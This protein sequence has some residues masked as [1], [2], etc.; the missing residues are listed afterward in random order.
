MLAVLSITAPIF[1]LMAVGFVSVK[2]GWLQKTDT[3]TLGMVVLNFALPG[4]VFHALSQQPFEKIL[5]GDYLI[6]YGG[7][8]LVAYVASMIIA[9]RI[10]RKTIQISALHGLGA[11]SSNSGFIGYAVAFTVVGDSAAIGLAL[12]MIIENCFILPVT[13]ALAESQRGRG[14]VMGVIGKSLLS[15]LKKPMVL[16]MIAG[17]AISASGLPVPA[18]VAKSVGMLATAAAPVA[19]LVIGAMLADVRIRGMLRDVVQIVSSK[20]ILHPVAVWGCALLVPGLDPSL[21][22]AAILF[23]SVPM[24]TIFPLLG[25]PYQQEDMCAASLM[26]ATFTSFFTISM[27][28]AIV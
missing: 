1:L 7:G 18:F 11:S 16:A 17:C 25:Q 20:L 4:L 10:F 23:A 21:R 24:V 22:V 27:F 8:T 3:R 2:L 5:N 12:N 9:W 19:L 13:I 26:L 28:L 14:N 15:V 6:A